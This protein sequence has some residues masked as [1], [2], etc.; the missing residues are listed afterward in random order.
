MTF[1]YITT[2]FLEEEVSALYCIYSVQNK[3]GIF[4]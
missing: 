4:N 1:C 3:Y 2:P